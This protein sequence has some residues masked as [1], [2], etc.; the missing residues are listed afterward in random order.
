MFLL[1]SY[2]DAIFT[3][4]Y[5]ISLQLRTLILFSGVISFLEYSSKSQSP[6]HVRLSHSADKVGFHGGIKIA[7][8]LKIEADRRPFGLENKPESQ[9]LECPCAG[10]LK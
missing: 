4:E 1:V 6:N 9:E 5:F 7:P 10:V 3:C 2:S 8:I